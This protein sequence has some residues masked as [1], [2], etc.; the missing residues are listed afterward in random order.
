MVL[1]SSLGE[2]LRGGFFENAD[3]RSGR[4]AGLSKE[5]AGEA[6]NLMRR[7]VQMENRNATTSACVGWDFGNIENRSALR[8]EAGSL[9]CWQRCPSKWLHNHQNHD[10][11]HQKGRYLVA[12]TIEFLTSGIPVGGEI[13]HAAGKKTMD[14]RQQQHQQ[15]FAVEPARRKQMTGPGEVKSRQPR[16]DHRRLDDRLQQPPFHHLEGF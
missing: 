14:T 11:D 10:A 1:W 7:P 12:K 8:K 15:Q 9:S 2:E 5:S 3:A 4:S 16:H 13:L 6:S